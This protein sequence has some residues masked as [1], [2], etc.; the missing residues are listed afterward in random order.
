MSIHEAAEKGDI[1]QLKQLLEDKP[2]DVNLVA[3]DFEDKRTPLMGAALSGQLEAVKMLIAHKAAVDTA[4]KLGR[5][6]LHFACLKGFA[7]IAKFLLDS[8]AE[9]DHGDH[10]GETALLIAVRE[11]KPTCVK[12]LLARKANTAMKATRDY[13]QPRTA[14]DIAKLS[15]FEDIAALLASSAI[16][17]GIERGDAKQEQVTGNFY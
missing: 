2:S 7:E 15:S 11:N 5:H 10:D 14:L 17:T 3:E 13:V 12:L 16:P 1:Q 4:D 8:G 9:I 6:A